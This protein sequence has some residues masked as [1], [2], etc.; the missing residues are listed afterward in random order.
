MPINEYNDNNNPILL[1]L[2]VDSNSRMNSNDIENDIWA[3]CY[4]FFSF[5]FI[6][7]C[8]LTWDTSMCID[9]VE[10]WMIYN[11]MLCAKKHRDWFI[12][13][14]NQ[15]RK[16]PDKDTTK[17][18]SIDTIHLLAFVIWLMC[19]HIKLIDLDST[20]DQISTRMDSFHSRDSIHIKCVRSVYSTQMCR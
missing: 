19:V 16:T 3:I 18:R 13:C 20:R 1:N 5:S 4:W 7:L 9:I 17:V 12:T 6:L 8:L 15:L 11:F 10:L 14:W 2:P